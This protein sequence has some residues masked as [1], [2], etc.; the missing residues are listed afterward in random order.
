M[1][2]FRWTFPNNPAQF[3]SRASLA[4]ATAFILSHLALGA[5]TP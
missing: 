5:A 1:T 2:Y 3:G 4:T